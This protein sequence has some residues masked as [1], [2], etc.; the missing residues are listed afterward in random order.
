MPLLDTQQHATTGG[1]GAALPAR[2]RGVEDTVPR[3]W[4]VTSRSGV[5]GRHEPGLGGERIFALWSDP[6]AL[7]GHV[8]TVHMR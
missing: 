6:L 3:P 5:R 4:G 8:S 2:R 1:L 7:P